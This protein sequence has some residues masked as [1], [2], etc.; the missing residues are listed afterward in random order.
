MDY[1]NWPIKT[2]IILQWGDMDAFSHVNNIN[3]IKWCETSRIEL[4]REMWGKSSMVQKDIIEGD[5]VGPI[6]ANFNINYRVALVYPDTAIIYTRVSKVGNSS[7]GVE[8]VL[9]SKKNGD[10]IVA[11]A[12]SVIVM[13]D[14]VKNVNSKLT[15]E[16]KEKLSRFMVYAK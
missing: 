8:H 2:E 5:G 7:Y 1:K 14:Y 13:F 10:N 11:D 16:Q 12:T 3:Y 9:C 15:K 4:F 6:L